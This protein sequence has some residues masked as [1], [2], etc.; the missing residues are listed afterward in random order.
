MGGHAIPIPPLQSAGIDLASI[1]TPIR[2]KARPESDFSTRPQRY[3]GLPEIRPIGSPSIPTQTNFSTRPQRYD[4]D[5]E[6]RPIGSPLIVTPVL[7]RVT[8]R[9]TSRETDTVS[10]RPLH[11][12]RIQGSTPVPMATDTPVQARQLISTSTTPS[13]SYAVL[14]D[15]DSAARRLF[16]ETPQRA[17]TVSSTSSLS[18]GAANAGLPDRPNKPVMPDSSTPKPMPPSQPSSK[19]ANV[20]KSAFKKGQGD[21]FGGPSLYVSSRWE[22]MRSDGLT[23]GGNERLTWQEEDK[24]VD[25]ALSRYSQQIVWEIP[26]SRARGQL[27]IRLDQ[28]RAKVMAL[29]PSVNEGRTRLLDSVFSALRKLPPSDIFH[30]GLH[31]GAPYSM[32][33]KEDLDRFSDIQSWWTTSLIDAACITAQHRLERLSDGETRLKGSPMEVRYARNLLPWIHDEYSCPVPVLQ[34]IFL[35]PSLYTSL[36]WPALGSDASWR[37]RITVA[38]VS[39]GF[40][41][42]F[43]CLAIFGPARLVIPFDGRGGEYDCQQLKDVSLTYTKGLVTDR[44]RWPRLLQDR[45]LY[46]SY[47][48]MVDP[49]QNDDWIF[50]PNTPVSW[51]AQAV[52]RLVSLSLRNYE[53]RSTGCSSR[54]SIL[55]GLWRQRQRS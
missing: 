17:V 1:V 31:C 5:P 39:V 3:D 47:R 27:M 48:G 29:S 41:T 46:E 4:G 21:A 43:I 32:V 19:Y 7:S 44:K 38:V 15:G 14:H 24:L 45:L 12:W 36:P 9:E 28:N 6:I 13:S 37:R 11:G 2:F 16:V 33:D 26:E 20:Y 18:T 30:R 55:A 50:A 40:N 8:S 34:D 53:T 25:R 42:H 52:I 54:T 23:P 49:S 10:G 35:S 22:G 51:R